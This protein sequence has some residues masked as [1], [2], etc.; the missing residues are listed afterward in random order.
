MAGRPQADSAVS[1]P[2]PTSGIDEAAHAAATSH[3]NDKLE[4]TQA[5]KKAG[6]YAKGHANINGLDISVENPAGSV[7]RGVDKDGTA[8]LQ[9]MPCSATS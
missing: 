8:S 2:Q 1:A 5:Q 3:L 7:R 9:A 4:P 6:N